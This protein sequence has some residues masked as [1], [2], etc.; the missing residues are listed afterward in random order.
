MAVN[1]KNN[2]II[3]KIFCKDSN[4]YLDKIFKSNNILKKNYTIQYV[5][6]NFLPN[7]LNEIDV[8][9]FYLKENYSIKASFPTRI[10]EY[11]SCGIPIL[12][13][14]FNHDITNLIQFNKIGLIINFNNHEYKKTYI[15]ICNLLSNKKIN[16]RC[17]KLAERKLSLQKGVQSYLQLYNKLLV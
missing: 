10:A 5:E 9:I 2:K 11:L 1:F 13:N 7:E 3:I 6:R 15:N 12:C 8:G 17:R 16:I 14:D 4:D